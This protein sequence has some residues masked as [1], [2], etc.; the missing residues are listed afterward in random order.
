MHLNNWRRGMDVSLAVKT[1][2]VQAGMKKRAMGS[3]QEDRQTIEQ[4][5][6]ETKERKKWSAQEMNEC[7]K[8]KKEMKNKK[9]K[10]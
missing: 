4:R 8:S 7:G 6:R 1:S 9:N 10:K 3:R 5:E 2:D